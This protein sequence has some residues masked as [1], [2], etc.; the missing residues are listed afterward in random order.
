MSDGFSSSKFVTAFAPDAYGT[1]AFSAGDAVDL[2]GFQ[3]AVFV[4]QVGASAGTIT[5]QLETSAASGSGYSDVSG[6]TYAA[7]TADQVAVIAVRAEK[8]SQ[9]V[10]FKAGTVATGA[11]DM[12]ALCILTN[13]INTAN[14]ATTPDVVI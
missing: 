12:G 14:Y 9:Y 3:Y 10:R 13:S 8:V 7:G 5:L 11:M 1:G 2:S 6:A 4:I